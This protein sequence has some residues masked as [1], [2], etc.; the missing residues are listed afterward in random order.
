MLTS[1]PFKADSLCAMSE[2]VSIRYRF[3]PPLIPMVLLSAS[4][5][6]PDQVTVK[7]I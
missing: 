7:N 5:T 3:H 4:V 1:D 2:S 6:Y